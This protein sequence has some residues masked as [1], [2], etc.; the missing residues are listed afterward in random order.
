[1]SAWLGQYCLNVADLERSV[2]W[3]SALGLECTSRTEIPAA[4]EAIME[5]PVGGGKLQLA[6]QKDQH[7]PV[8]LGSAFWKLYVNTHNLEATFEAAQNLAAEVVPS[9]RPTAG[10]QQRPRARS[11]LVNACAA[12]T[13][14]G[15]QC[16]RTQQRV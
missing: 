15:F 12:R 3:Y 4:F 11:I 14:G 5:S 6:Q 16:G 7:G 1:M 9:S 2:A 8:A 13:S 10:H